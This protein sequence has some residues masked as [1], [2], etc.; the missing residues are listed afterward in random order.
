MA[1]QHVLASTRATPRSSARSRRI[2]SLT[3]LVALLAAPAGADTLF[4]TN[5]V[6][7]VVDGGDPASVE[8]GVKFES[9]V[10]GLVTGVRFYKAATNT[11]THIGNLWSAGGVNLATATFTNETATGWQQVNFTPPVQIAANTIYVA[12]YFAPQGHYSGNL[13]Y[14]ATQGV[15]N[16]PL[17]APASTAVVGGNGVY[18]YGAA[19][20]FPENTFD[21]VN[22]WVDVVFSPQTAP[23]LTSI[24]ISPVDP[25]V[26]IGGTQPFM[27][28]GQFSDGTFEDVT[29]EVVWSSLDP[30]VASVTKD[31]LAT[32][33]NQGT[34]TI[35]ASSGTVVDETTLTV[36]PPGGLASAT[37]SLPVGVPGTS[38]TATVTTFGGT[39]SLTW[40]VASGSLPRGLT[41]SPSAGV[42][43]GTPTAIGMSSFT[44]QVSGGGQTAT[45]PF[46][47][48]IAQNKI[49]AENAL[50]GNPSTEWDI[51][52]AGDPSIQG[53]ATD[54]SFNPGDT[55]NFK[56]DTDSSSYRIDIYRLG[57]YDGLGARLVATVQPSARLPQ[58]QPA[59]LSDVS[60]GLLDCGNWAV[61]ASWTVPPTATSGIY[62]A[63][64][65][66]Q[67]P[68]DGR[69][70]HI[71]FVVRDDG[72]HSDLLFQT[73]DTTWQAY[74]TYGGNSLY[75]GSPAGRAYKV[76]YNRPFTT[77]CCEFPHGY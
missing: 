13:A 33:V 6:P 49:V 56:V 48:S 14:F 27:A 75:F 37:T 38:Y 29:N 44:L 10:T 52:G 55:A 54:I 69:A 30:A 40:T 12:S 23:T 19:T 34:A 77:R 42:I 2:W 22:Y 17:H 72:G 1:D 25:E 61:S 21:A 46:S 11:G 65:V 63:K 16:A 4:P 36:L 15:D 76:S 59:C 71:P 74:N 57:Y 41:L 8:L 31:G 64:L 28:T 9:D 3:L 7:A 47:I 73:S 60:T 62:I 66:R 20:T 53:F 39:A 68:E 50:P 43:S 67:D 51:T 70:S 5:P 18:S 32:G 24:S 26:P 35:S 58:T 45:R